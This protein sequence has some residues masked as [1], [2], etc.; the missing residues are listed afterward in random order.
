MLLLVL[1]KS[2]L[3][4]GKCSRT[5]YLYNCLVDLTFSDSLNTQSCALALT[6]L[7]LMLH[8]KRTQG[9]KCLKERKRRQQGKTTHRRARHSRS[10]GHLYRPL[11]SENSGG[12]GHCGIYSAVDQLRQQGFNASLQSLRTNVAAFLIDN[13]YAWSHFPQD[14]ASDW[15]LFVEQVGYTGPG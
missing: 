10:A 11:P 5:L 3:R 13:K 15:A 1:T 12:D 8:V 2:L 14:D 7:K 6:H 9:P 4:G